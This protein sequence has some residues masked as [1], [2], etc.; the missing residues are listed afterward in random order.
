[1]SPNE[2]ELQEVKESLN[3]NDKMFSNLKI[4][5]D[6]II[7]N[8][9]GTLRLFQN[10]Y[11]IANDIIYKYEK[12]NKNED[13]EKEFLNFTILKTPRNLKVSN[14]KITEDLDSLI[15]QKDTITKAFYL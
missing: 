14:K 12:F 9:N 1:M 5:I 4:S 10:Y 7:Y 11:E 8:L 15:K 13:K 2:V 3:K 6:N